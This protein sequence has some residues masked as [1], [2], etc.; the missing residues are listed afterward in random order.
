MPP[1]SKSNTFSSCLLAQAPSCQLPIPLPQQTW[2]YQHSSWTHRRIQPVK[3]YTT[4]A[5]NLWAAKESV[6]WIDTVQDVR[7]TVG[8]PQKHKAI[9]LRGVASNVWVMLWPWLH[10]AL[11]KQQKNNS[12]QHKEL[13]F[14]STGC[15]KSKHDDL[16]REESHSSSEDETSPHI[17]PGEMFK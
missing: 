15:R 6:T 17:R 7:V 13:P 16:E 12:T 11:L 1:N 8:S 3:I 4:L 5:F 9:D 10:L 2:Y 14:D